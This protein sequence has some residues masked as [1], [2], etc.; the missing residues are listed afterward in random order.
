LKKNLLI[1]SE[2]KNLK[3]LPCVCS[4]NNIGLYT[5]TITKNINFIDIDID[6]YDKNKNNLY[7]FINNIL[8]ND[9]DN[10]NKLN[11]LLLKTS[12]EYILKIKPF[13]EQIENEIIELNSNYEKIDKLLLDI[14]NDYLENEKIHYIY[15]YNN[16]NDKNN[17]ELKIK[18]CSEIFFNNDINHIHYTF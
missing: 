4:N 5:K 10:K 14:I 13:K 9:S 12:G 8:V 7:K 17:F 18:K 11:I 1:L 6:L 15:P 2:L 3:L 16:V